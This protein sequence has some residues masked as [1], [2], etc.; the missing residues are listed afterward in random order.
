MTISISPDPDF[1][2][3][4][5]GPSAS[6]VD[7]MLGTMGVSSTAELVDSTVPSDIRMEGDLGVGSPIP[8]DDEVGEE[9]GEKH[10]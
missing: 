5:L 8:K 4:H 3:R 10:G 2:P 6:D 7:H 1:A 9:H